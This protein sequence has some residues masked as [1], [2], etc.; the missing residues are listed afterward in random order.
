MRNVHSVENGDTSWG[1][2]NDMKEASPIKT[3]EYAVAHGI[4]TEPTFNWWAQYT[5]KKRDSIIS[6]V[7]PQIVRRDYK[8]GIKVPAGIAEVRALDK[9]NGDDLWEPSVEKEMK[10]VW[11]AFKFL[12]NVTRVPVRYQQ[13]PYML[14]MDFTRKYAW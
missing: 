2:L 13:I 9:E 12:D 4:S 11:I 7:R 5:L 10:N 8:F 14:K 3:A 1:S 6:T